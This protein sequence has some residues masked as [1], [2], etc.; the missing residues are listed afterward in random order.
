VVPAVLDVVSDDAVDLSEY[1]IVET[2]DGHAAL[3]N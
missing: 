3:A 1:E 2:D